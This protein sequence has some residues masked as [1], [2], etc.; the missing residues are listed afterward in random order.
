MGS[1][2]R[3]SGMQSQRSGRMLQIASGCLQRGD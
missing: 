3:V 1:Y 2:I